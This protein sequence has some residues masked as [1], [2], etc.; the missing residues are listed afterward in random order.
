MV[1][2]LDVSDFRSM[3]G[4][5]AGGDGPGECP[6]KISEGDL[7]EIESL[8]SRLLTIALIGKRSKN[9]AS[10]AGSSGNSFDNPTTPAAA[11]RVSIYSQ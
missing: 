1:K 9:A 11:I 10:S 8:T 6:I 2:S 4:M 5:V 7:D 3:L